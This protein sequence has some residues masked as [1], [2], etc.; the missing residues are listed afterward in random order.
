PGAGGKKVAAR[1]PAEWQVVRM[2]LWKVF[3]KPVRI[4]G[5]HLASTGGPAALDQ[6]LLGRA[7]KDLPAAKKGGGAEARGIEA[8]PRRPRKVASLL[9]GACA[10]S[11]MGGRDWAAR[12]ARQ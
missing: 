6:V 1:P 3:K 12:A 5:L 11:K 9:A 2:D 8:L 7:A 10:G 4:R